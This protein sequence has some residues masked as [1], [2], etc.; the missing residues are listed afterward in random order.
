MKLLVAAGA[1]PT[2]KNGA[3][4][5]AVYEAERAEKAEVVEFLLRE[6]KQVETGAGR[7]D[8][9]EEESLRSGGG[10]EEGGDSTEGSKLNG[11]RMA[12]GGI[13]DGDVKELEKGMEGMATN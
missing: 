5:D 1:D 3:G 6:C 13:D 2:R 7:F 4:H 9:V 8:K 12:N 11:G 10:D